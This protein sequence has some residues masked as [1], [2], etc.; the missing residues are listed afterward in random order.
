MIHFNIMVTICWKS[1][2][3]ILREHW[4]IHTQMLHGINTDTKKSVFFF[5]FLRLKAISMGCTFS[6]NVWK[7]FFFFFP[8]VE[9]QKTHPCA[10]SLHWIEDPEIQ[11]KSRTW[12]LLFDSED[13]IR[14]HLDEPCWL[15][16]FSE[17]VLLFKSKQKGRRNMVQHL[18]KRCVLYDISYSPE[19]FFFF[20]FRVKSIL[21]IVPRITHHYL[22]QLVLQSNQHTTL[23]V[24][25]AF[26]QIKKDSAR[27]NEERRK[28][29]II[30]EKRHI[31]DECMTRC[32]GFWRLQNEM[33]R[34]PNQIQLRMCLFVFFFGPW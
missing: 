18:M 12:R 17:R 10:L 27:A 24:L 7:T 29:E 8:K 2:E 14:R 28:W 3:M 33:Q 1:N 23:S 19:R 16:P 15:H 22:P 31:L 4:G 30:K 6:P 11:R 25:H 20:F 21:F 13:P 26:I 34:H 9:K 32:F 5:F